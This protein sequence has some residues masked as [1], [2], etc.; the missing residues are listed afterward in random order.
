MVRLWDKIIRKRED[1]LLALRARVEELETELKG[2][3]LAADKLN[4]A[5]DAAC[6]MLKDRR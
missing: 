5:Y 6:V 4:R 1:E 3:N 2:A